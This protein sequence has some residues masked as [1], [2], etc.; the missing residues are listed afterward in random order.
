MS[1]INA[2]N[3][4]SHPRWE[5]MWSEGINPGDRFDA[6]V[7]SPLLKKYIEGLLLLY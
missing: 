6:S 7:I 5:A 2:S 3:D 4:L 1:N